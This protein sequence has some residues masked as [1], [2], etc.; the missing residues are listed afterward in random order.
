[1]GVAKSLAAAAGRAFPATCA[2]A[3]IGL[4]IATI[5]ASSTIH[6][7]LRIARFNRIFSARGTFVATGASTQKR[8]FS[9]S[10][11]I[12]VVG[13]ARATILA[14]TGIAISLVAAGRAFPTARAFASVTVTI[15]ASD[16]AAAVLARTIIAR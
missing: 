6:A 9:S 15:A 14:R 8:V 10:E 2:T 12:V 16:T 11:V 1:L 4:S 7:R 5:V 3:S 13:G